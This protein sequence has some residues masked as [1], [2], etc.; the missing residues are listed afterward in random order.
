MQNQVQNA[1]ELDYCSETRPSKVGLRSGARP[2]G[3]S[4]AERL[5][6]AP[7]LALLWDWRWRI[8]LR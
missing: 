6:M 3:R 4:G 2:N 8:W 5:Q 1:R 7:H